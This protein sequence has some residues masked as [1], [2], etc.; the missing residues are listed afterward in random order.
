MALAVALEYDVNY[1]RVCSLVKRIIVLHGGYIGR[2]F[3]N[4]W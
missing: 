2:Y 4:R 1:T 3:K